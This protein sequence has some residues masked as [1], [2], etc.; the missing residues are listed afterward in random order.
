MLSKL[1]VGAG[2]FLMALCGGQIGRHVGE[3]GY[4]LLAGFAVGIVC[5]AQ[6]P[7]LA[8]RK[9]VEEL[10]SKLGAKNIVEHDASL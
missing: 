7:T 9:R 10:E 2:A 8:L 6:A 4:L 3:Y 1:M 5:L